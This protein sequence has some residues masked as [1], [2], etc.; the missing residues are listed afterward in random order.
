MASTGAATQRHGVEMTVSGSDLPEKAA[1]RKWRFISARSH[2]SN[3]CDQS[4]QNVGK[5]AIGRDE[6]AQQC[7]GSDA[8]VSSPG[9]PHFFSDPLQCGNKSM[10]HEHFSRAFSGAAC[11]PHP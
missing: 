5:W 10:L 9:K 4:G 1:H 7:C 3:L 8:H 2:D 6:D 11:A